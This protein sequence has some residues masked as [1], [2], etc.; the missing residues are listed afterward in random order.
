MGKEKK[1]AKKETETKRGGDK[2]A[3]T[4]SETRS[5]SASSPSMDSIPANAAFPG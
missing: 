3:A 1:G 4:F 5:T 2:G